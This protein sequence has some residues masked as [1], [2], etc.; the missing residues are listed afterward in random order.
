VIREDAT[1]PLN[2]LKPRWRVL[3]GSHIGAS[4]S[5][6]GAPCQDSH[7]WFADTDLVVLA[8]ADGAG[9]RPHSHL[10][11]KAAVESVLTWVSESDDPSGLLA[12]AF[13]KAREAVAD[14]ASEVGLTTTELATTLAVA[15]ISSEV[16]TICQ[17]G[18]SIPILRDTSGTHHVCRAPRHEY[19]NEVVFLT[20]PDALENLQKV[21]LDGAIEMVSLS[22]DGLRYKI[23]DVASGDPYSPFFDDLFTYAKADDSTSEGIVRFL[24]RVDDQTGDDKTLIVAVHDEA[25]TVIGTH[26][27]V[28]PEDRQQ[29]VAPPSQDEAVLSSDGSDNRPGGSSPTT[30]DQHGHPSDHTGEEV[31]AQ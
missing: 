26:R 7:G 9:S 29:V 31:E 5:T 3:G 27:H 20:A 8:V 19:A 30:A 23:L 18:D 1:D 10:G 6:T 11:S 14:A 22:T 16:V 28:G 24:G 15:V 13:E 17:I 25:H 2:G 21:V 12:D 4:H